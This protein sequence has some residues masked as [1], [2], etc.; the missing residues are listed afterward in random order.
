MPLVVK[1]WSTRVLQSLH[2]LCRV[3]QEEADKRIARVTIEETY[4]RQVFS[5]TLFDRACAQLP[6][7]AHPHDVRERHPGEN[8]LVISQISNLDILDQ[9]HRADL[10]K[11]GRPGIEAVL[12]KHIHSRRGEQWMHSGIRES[13]TPNC[14]GKRS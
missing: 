9:L 5:L 10:D 7:R 6:V 8:P 4:R 13:P 12:D 3:L 1:E 11:P 2:I 14:Q